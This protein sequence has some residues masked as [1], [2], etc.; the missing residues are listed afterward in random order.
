[1]AKYEWYGRIR[2]GWPNHHGR[3]RLGELLDHFGR[4]R[5]GWPNPN[6]IAAGSL[7]PSPNRTA[8]S[9]W[10]SPN[11]VAESPWPNLNSG[12]IVRVGWPNHHGRIRI[13]AEY[14]EWGGRIR[15][16]DAVRHAIVRIPGNRA[17]AVR[18]VQRCSRFGYGLGKRN[19][20]LA[21]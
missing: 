1:M 9:P 5:L 20:H 11:S 12:R 19:C 8:E 14:T 13:V 17:G 2:L 15:I 4:V 18:L 3:V 7:W 6:G 10:P 21:A 16:G